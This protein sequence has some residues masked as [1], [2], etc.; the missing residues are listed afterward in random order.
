M[1]IMTDYGK[2]ARRNGM[3]AGMFAMTCMCVALF[4][5]VWRIDIGAPQGSPAFLEAW[6]AIEGF[7]GFSLFGS[8]GVVALILSCLAVIMLRAS[9]RPITRRLVALGACLAWFAA[10]VFAVLEVWDTR[11][12][13]AGGVEAFA[14][15]TGGIELAAT[16]VPE[17]GAVFLILGLAGFGA[18]LFI[19]RR[20]FFPR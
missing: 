12:R 17:A 14:M 7:S 20:R 5:P 6:F 9:V 13:I 8:L 10:V 2:G 18:M 3:L 19:E 11:L 4:S 15:S 16:S 1:A